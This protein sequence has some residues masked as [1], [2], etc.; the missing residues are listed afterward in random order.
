MNWIAAASLSALF[1]GVVSVL[2][3]LGLAHTDSDVATA[4]RTTV[5]LAFAWIVALVSG[6]IGQIATIGP[7][8]WAFLILS[9]AA[10]GASWICY[11]K[12]LSVGDVNKVVPIDKSSAALSSLLA[13][14]LFTET[15]NLAIRLAAIAAT[16]VGTL[17]MIEKRQRPDTA[18]AGGRGW[19]FW[20]LAAA[21]FAALTSILGKAGI[22]GVGS[23]V[24]T[25]IRTCVVLLMAWGIVLAR[26]KARLVG[27]TNKRELLFLALSGIA[28]GASWLFYYYALQQGVV[29]AVVQ[30]DRLSVL[31][32]VGFAFVFL[33]ERLS[34]RATAGLALIVIGAFALTACS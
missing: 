28:T 19:L 32:S 27:T 12:A 20:A 14:A 22:D 1:A 11:F 25:A 33:K 24:G 6:E 26:G 30:I 18:Q 17:L 8:T 2:A 9:G 16:F 13:I 15:E 31:V 5:V 3:K 7:S 4:I 29:S 23:N 10:T 34:P 21:V